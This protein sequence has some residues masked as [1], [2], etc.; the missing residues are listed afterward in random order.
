M[1]VFDYIESMKNTNEM[2]VGV[3]G[4]GILALFLLV[5]VLKMLGGMRRGVWR[6][7][8]RTGMTLVAAGISYFAAVYLSNSIIGCLSADN[9]EELIVYADS[10]FPGIGDAMR[11]TLSSINTELIEYI[12]LVPATLIIL[13]L[14]ATIIFLVIN[15]VLKIVR[16][17]I[18][19]IVG[20]KKASNNAERLGGALL[21]GVEGI[22]WMIMITLPFSAILSLTNS[23]YEKAIEAT[24][25][26]EP[27]ETSD[28]TESYNQNTL[29]SKLEEQ[30]EDESEG[31]AFIELYEEYVAPFTKN[32][33]SMFIQQV[34]ANALADG[35][36]TVNIDNKPTNMRGEVLKVADVVVE[37]TKLAEADF[38]ALNDGEK[39]SIT[40]IVSTLSE[41]TVMSKMIVGTLNTIPTLVEE[42]IIPLDLGD[43]PVNGLVES[44]MVFL[45]ETSTETLEEDLNTL[46][47]VYFG[48]CDSG[49][50]SAVTNG[51]DVMEAF[52]EGKNELLDA[53]NSLSGNERTEDIVDSMYDVVINAAFGNS[54]PSAP[55]N[56]E[57]F[58]DD[59][60]GDMGNNEN[61]PQIGVQDIKDGISQIAGIEKGNKTDEE[62][63]EELSEAIIDVA[64]DKLNVELEKDMAIEA[65]KFIN[66]NL[67]E[68]MEKLEQVTKDKIKFNELVFALLDAYQSFNDGEDID[69][70]QFE[71]ILDIEITDRIDEF[72]PE[73]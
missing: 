71:Q 28:A 52:K 13:P 45:E 73:E 51:D 34:G 49:I 14:V 25:V 70:E 43:T 23:V 30:Q 27:A 44:V 24:Q 63:I 61:A 5:I 46:T 33:A 40:N 21:A 47:D 2:F 19:K 67:S 11:S 10:Y 35:I 55:D 60:M 32:P 31:N 8:V 12:I 48:L 36:A 53:M 41:S 38:T 22:I 1:N 18:I 72:I 69:L 17:I 3:A 64:K 57:S 50:I 15:L 26:V 58:G 56:D 29:A 54:A 59:S 20:F 37:A 62:Y 4:L 9:L 66:D 65:A 42:E 39:K 68:E 16:A 6:Q 7:L